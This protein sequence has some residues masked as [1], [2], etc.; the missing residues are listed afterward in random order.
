MSTLIIVVDTIYERIIDITLRCVHFLVRH[1]TEPD[2]H[3]VPSYQQEVSVVE[4]IEEEVT[5]QTFKTVEEILHAVPLTEKKMIMYAGSP[6]VP[7]YKNPT[8]EFDALVASIPF[9]EAVMMREP[10]GRFFSVVWNN[11]EGWVLK[12]DLVDR[13]VRIYPEFVPG[14]ENTVDSDSTIR[15]RSIIGDVFGLRYSEFPLQSG[16]YI[17]YKLW[18][19]GVKVTW[20]QVRPRI[21]GQWHV[22]LKGQQHVHMSVTPKVGAVMEYTL[23][24]EI[25]H[26]A[27]VEAV[28]PDSTIAISEAH[29]PDSGI[30]NERELTK[31][32]WLEL[33]P[34]F[35]QFS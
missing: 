13:A 15:V 19:K 31:V 1:S 16:E 12:E 9:G 5:P 6:E 26:L 17:L 10:K 24:N 20:P 33:K 11:I 32:E 30:Y 3:E 21:P 22:I 28:F 27:Y 29:Y 18:R 23:D 8:I 25:G 14:E 2:V 4:S 34:I 7:L 35:I